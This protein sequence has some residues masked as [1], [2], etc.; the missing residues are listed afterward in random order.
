MVEVEVMNEIAKKITELLID[1]DIIKKIDK[2]IYI[3]GIELF[4]ISV[5]EIMFILLISI[6]V[7]N[8]LETAIFLAAFLPIRIYSGGYHADTKWKCFI[9]LIAVYVIFTI[10][11]KVIPWGIYSILFMV[12]SIITII[13]VALMAPLKNKNK[14][15]NEREYK[16]YKIISICLSSAEGI[17]LTIMILLNLINMIS[18]SIALSLLTVLIS[19][20]AGKVKNIFGRRRGNG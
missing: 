6:V 13:C 3:Y 18:K 8:F 19:L 20:I 1:D 10:C 16:S 15:F 5:L 4:L 12:V 11:L 17:I 7:G 2:D 9:I 14:T